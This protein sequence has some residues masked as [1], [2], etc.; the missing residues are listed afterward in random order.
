MPVLA[1]NYLDP[2]GSHRLGAGSDGKVFTLV[3]DMF[4][5]HRESY[6]GGPSS[7]T[8]PMPTP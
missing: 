7:S 6:A 8:H 1:R 5:S 3:T 2:F 4:G